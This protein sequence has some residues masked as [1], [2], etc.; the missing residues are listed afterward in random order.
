MRATRFSVCAAIVSAV[1]LSAATTASVAQQ[2]N[3]KKQESPPKPL[4]ADASP[5][6]PCESLTSVAIPNTTID[7][8]AI[9]PSDGSCR[10]TATVTHP[11]AG[12]RVKVF[13]ALPAKGWNGRFRGNGG[14]G[15][16][17]G[18]PNSLRGRWH[19]GYVA[20]FHG[21]GT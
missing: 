11:P 14:G 12:D 5:I 7:S 8:A 15:F 19:R 20:A 2:A 17:G 1:L 13:I 16:S 9:D 4:Y 10:V 3:Q 6:C 18:N 21:H